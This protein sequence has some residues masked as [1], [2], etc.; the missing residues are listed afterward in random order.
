ML[1]PEGITKHKQHFKAMILAKIS[2]YN[3]TSCVGY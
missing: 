1:K 2:G 3:F